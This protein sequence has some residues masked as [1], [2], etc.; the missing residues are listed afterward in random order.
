V[1]ATLCTIVTRILFNVLKHGGNYIYHLLDYNGTLPLV[2]TPYLGLIIMY[3]VTSLNNKDRS[4][5]YGPTGTTQCEL[6][7]VFLVL[8]VVHNLH[9]FQGVKTK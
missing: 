6:C 5:F 9:A 4:V 3:G 1:I 8:C 2:H 7:L